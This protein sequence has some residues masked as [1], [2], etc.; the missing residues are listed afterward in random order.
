M[1][2]KKPSQQASATRKYASDQDIEQLAERLAGK[3]YGSPGNSTPVTEAEDPLK[4]TTISLPA[5]LLD[6][7]EDT[8]LKNKR[9]GRDPKSVSALVRDALAEYFKN[10][11]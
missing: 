6:K 4:R 7:T 2:L 11:P 3:P 1:A 5:S 10:H 9:S 8:A